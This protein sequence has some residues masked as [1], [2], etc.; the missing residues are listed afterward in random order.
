MTKA[1][2]PATGPV[3]LRLL[4]APR[5]E[6]P[7][8][9]ARAL[10][11][12]GAALLAMLALHGPTPRARAAA[13]IWPDV[14]D[15]R[16]GNSLRQRMFKLRQAAGRDVIVPGRLLTLASDIVHD[17]APPLPRLELD[18]DSCQGGLLGDLDFS[19]C[20]DLDAWVGVARQRWRDEVG[21]SLAALSS[22]LEGEGRIAA[23]LRLA[24]RLIEI[25]PIQEH[26]H[27]RVMRLHYLR[28][29]R[30]AAL[31]AFDRCRV[32]LRGELGVLPD[33]ET[34][35]L[36]QLIA[37][38][39]P[40]AARTTPPTPVSVLRPPRLI[41]RETEWRQLSRAGAM[42]R[43]VL[44][45]GEPGIG[46][47]RL[48]NDYAA[49]QRGVVV[50]ARPGDASTPY[51]AIARLLRAL[52][53]AGASPDESAARVL[54]RLLP[55][56]GHPAPGALEPLQL[57]MAIAACVHAAMDSGLRV[58]AF[59]DA[60]FAD[61][62]SLELL[63]ALS[64][65]DSLSDAAEG[66]WLI[67]SR[68]GELPEPLRAWAAA[69][70]TGALT[71][72]VLAPLD[73]AAVQA[74]LESLGLPDFDAGRWAPAL[75][76]HT[77]GNPM[78]I[79][80]TLRAMLDQR[81]PLRDPQGA[82]LPLPADVGSLIERRL[83][84]LSPEALNLAHIAAL[85]GQDFTPD[86]AAQVLQR[87]VID[88]SE[89]WR[90][91]EQAQ[92]IRDRGFA[93]DLIVEALLRTL[94]RAIATS[95]HAAIARVLQRA[96]AAAARVAEHWAAAAEYAAAS[97]S[98][99]TAADEAR[100][101]SRLDEELQLLLRADDCMQLGALAAQ[102]TAVLSRALVAAFELGRFD[103]MRRFAATMEQIAATPQDRLLSLEG[104]MRMQAQ[105]LDFEGMLRTA[106]EALPLAERVGD[107]FQRALVHEL[108]ANALAR[109][110]RAA[111]AMQSLAV[112]TDWANR[113]PD[114]PWAS[115]ALVDIAATLSY[116]ERYAD[117]G[118]AA[119]LAYRAAERVGH[120]RHMHMASANIAM[121]AYVTGDVAGSAEEYERCRALALRYGGESLQSW[122]QGASLS[123]SLRLLG[124][125]DG[126]LLHAEQQIDACRRADPTGGEWWRVVAEIE[127]AHC[128]FELGQPGRARKVLGDQ[129]PAQT[130]ARF[131]WL[132]TRCRI[133]GVRLPQ[134][135]D[136]LDEAAVLARG[137]LRTRG[138]HWSLAIEQCRALPSPEAIELLERHVRDCRSADAWIYY[139]PLQL[140]LLQAISAAGRTGDALSLAREMQ[141]LAR[142]HAPAGP[143]L[144]E[145]Y[146]ALHQVF[147]SANDQV[148]S[149]IALRAAVDWIGNALPNVPEPLR[150][151]FTD[152]NPFN[153]AALTRASS[154]S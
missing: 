104:R 125:Y 53:A 32:V 138:K 28:G 30:A 140:R 58:I 8:G 126:A 29:D 135:R 93:H 49:A 131:R 86:L 36:E 110:G 33:R 149:A 120:V 37:Q 15:S 59:D 99:L 52:I 3:R 151:G 115:G 48:M 22:R 63:P 87:R 54:A 73:L 89:P 1:D 143:Y 108:K 72:L 83:A 31:A 21:R 133:E 51:A 114:H 96:N 40:Q 80:E 109:L 70:D 38:G 95:L 71:R 123:R 128:W 5:L 92:V 88:L 106:D 62:A 129:P 56:L 146:L 145:Y 142:E 47:S 60:Q 105:D 117:S 82:A 42:K 154:L 61:V 10:E 57:R 39:D 45:I 111:E 20:S 113:N 130:D 147:E 26:A 19:D 50:H 124:R 81:R 132:L 90:E 148:A 100:S 119:E 76:R 66:Q 25:E 75:L 34:Q 134:A 43:S 2:A 153:R 141:S 18:P 27:R 107:E 112:C 9:T 74:L 13:T 136:W 12:R 64:S 65:A 152:R 101:V 55:E 6:L 97:A 78:F 116:L 77:G 102:R 24:E 122:S 17:L 35:A 94:P 4:G 16:A 44:L 139:W 103:E 7:D 11:R 91:L 118:A 23:A 46:K 67:A 85:S 69:Q 79:L 121:I 41:G 150:D 137:G 127:L 98:F 84:Q 144:P 68:P 14:E